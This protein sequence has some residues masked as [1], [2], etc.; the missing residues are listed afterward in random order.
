MREQGHKF[1]V[2]SLLSEEFEATMGMYQGC[3]LL[4]VLFEIVVDIVTTFAREGTLSELLY[5][6]Y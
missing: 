5:A 2:C 4:P 1:R 3:V 6:D